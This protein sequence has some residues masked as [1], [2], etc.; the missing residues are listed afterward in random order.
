MLKKGRLI[1]VSTRAYTRM[2]TEQY[3]TNIRD[4]LIKTKI[5][6]TKLSPLL[7]ASKLFHLFQNFIL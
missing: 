5:S 7:E 3:L 6:E 2:S 4:S 1:A